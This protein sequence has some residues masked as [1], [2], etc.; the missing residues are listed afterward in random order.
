MKIL[1]YD[2]KRLADI[3]DEQA[4]KIKNTKT[5]HIDF[6]GN[7]LKMTKVEIFDTGT[8][9]ENEIWQKSTEELKEMIGEFENQLNEVKD[10][11]PLAVEGK[12][13][14]VKD[15]LLPDCG[16]YW[17]QDRGIATWYLK[18]G[19]LATIKKVDGKRKWTLTQKYNDDGVMQKD[20]ALDE[21]QE[22]RRFA[23]EEAMKKQDPIIKETF[24][25]DRKIKIANL[26]LKLAEK[27]G[28]TI[29]Q[30]VKNN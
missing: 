13:R 3:T 1:N 22:R 2:N 30:Y 26:R 20:I 21:L 16:M 28:W 14:A 24:E 29:K 27:M 7:F 4:E 9:R 15:G 11:I 19:W 10:N 25:Q 6:N 17:L 12:A 23:E 18:N 5:S 8:E